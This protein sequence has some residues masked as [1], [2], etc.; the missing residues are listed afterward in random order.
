MTGS[1]NKV[2]LL[3]ERVLE[4][5]GVAGRQGP[6]TRCGSCT[7]DVPMR[8][9]QDNDVPKKKN[10]CHYFDVLFTLTSSATNPLNI[11]VSETTP[12]EGQTRLNPIIRGLIL[13][14]QP[15]SCTWRGKS[16]SEEGK[17]FD[18]RF[19]QLHQ[20]WNL[21]YKIF[22]NFTETWRLEDEFF[23]VTH[24]NE[25]NYGA[26]GLWILLLWTHPLFSQGKAP[27]NHVTLHH[28][29]FESYR[30]LND[31]CWISH[32]QQAI[33]ALLSHLDGRDVW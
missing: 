27:L 20:T 6:G 2:V 9:H 1:W 29:V 19:R 8:N 10:L 16:N 21:S 23:S 14:S 11:L 5:D 7:T 17:P 32:L 3:D 12:Q 18:I 22:L 31:K 24:G 33:S 28:D 25:R 30:N 13:L 26:K 15:T 4:Q